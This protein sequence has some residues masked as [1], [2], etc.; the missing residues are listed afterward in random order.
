MAVITK[1]SVRFGGFTWALCTI[2]DTLLWCDA[3]PLPSQPADL[4]ITAASDG[5]HK[6]GSKH[7]TYEALD[8][9][10]KSFPTAESK[11]AFVTKLKAELGENFTVLFESE[12]Q[13]QE[14]FHVQKKRGIKD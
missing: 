7:Y 5:T 4:V 9:R 10:S 12:G 1:P 6:K 11:R 13:A 8:V 2:L 14:H 3:H